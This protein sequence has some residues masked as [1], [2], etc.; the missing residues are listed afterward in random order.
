M[1]KNCNCFKETL[2]I[3]FVVCGI[4]FVSKKQRIIKF[5]RK[6]QKK[7]EKTK[8]SNQNSI[9]YFLL[10]FFF[11]IWM[12]YEQR[13]CVLVDVLLFSLF[14]YCVG[15]VRNFLSRFFFII[16]VLF[17]ERKSMNF[18]CCWISVFSHKRKTYQYV[19]SGAWLWC[20]LGGKEW[21]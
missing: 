16:F 6:R 12:N 10:S 8:T 20:K 3:F 11:Y 2:N 21:R 7:N 14:F 15:F 9:S 17:L 19:G 13:M 18:Y 4:F 1:K 5:V